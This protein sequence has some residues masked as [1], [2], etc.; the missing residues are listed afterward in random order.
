M[1]KSGV[2][3]ADELV[4]VYQ[5]QRA[6]PSGLSELGTATTEAD[7]S[8]Q[9]T[10]PALAT[11]SMFVVRLAGAHRAST[12]VKVA[13]L[14]TISGPAADARVLTGGHASLT[15]T[16]TVTPV[17]SG[18]LV[19]LQREYADEQWRAIARGR[20]GPEGRYSIAYSFSAHRL[21]SPG[22]VSVRVV[23]YPNG[24]NIIAASE[25]LSYVV[26]QAQHSQLTIQT[27]TDPIS[28]GQ[29]V[30]ITGVLAGA[31]SQA[32]I[33]LARVRGGAFVPV[34]KGTTDA[35]GAYTF[36]V[37]PLRT[38]F[39]KVAAL[40]RTSTELFEGVKDVLTAGVSANTVQAGAQ[41]TFS[42]TLV[43]AH[44][45]D[46]VYLERERVNGVGFEVVDVGSVDAAGSYSI[47]HTFYGAATRVMRI[48]VPAS[49]ESQG[50]ISEPFTILVTPAPAPLESE[51]AP[52][53]SSAEAQA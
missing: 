41:L 21:S 43:P 36:T 6:G 37:S 18:A 48:R 50:S 31:A 29:S 53:S 7:G 26:S 23:V 10:P 20:V 51:E 2:S 3:T 16:G 19:R 52:G 9:F 5:R 38:T 27:S 22:E 34:A 15:V 12:V 1:C 42:G 24:P 8:F 13:P 4:T 35:A 14:V 47:V 28:P 11:N 44:V 32:V 45:G 40:A 39:Y 49:L 46:V 17:L 30:R 33:L 25:P